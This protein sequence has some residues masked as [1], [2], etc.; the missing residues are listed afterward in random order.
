MSTALAKSKLRD[1]E[2]ALACAQSNL[3]GAAAILPE[4]SPTGV[5]ASALRFMGA[6]IEEQRA[7]LE[8]LSNA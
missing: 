7:M 6:V 1:A 4:Q 2:R 3:A 5:T 8:E